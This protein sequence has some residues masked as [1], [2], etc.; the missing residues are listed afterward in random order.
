MCALCATLS[1]WGALRAQEAWR[2]PDR[3]ARPEA[4]TD[5]GGLWALMDRAEARLRRSPF[6]VRDGALRN[7]LHGIICRLTSRHCT[8]IRVY[9]VQNPLFNANMAPNGMTQVWTGLMLRMENEAQ[10]AAVLGHEIAHYLE[11]HTLERLRDQ[12]ATSA[13]GQFLGIFGAVGAIGQLALLAGLF[14]YS[15]EQERSADRIGLMLMH[16]AG[17]DPAE[18]ARVW[19]NLAAEAKARP[20]GEADLRIPLFATHPGVEERLETLSALAKEYA[21]GI[22]NA[23]TWQRQTLPFCGE[24]L[25]DEIQRGQ[26]EQSIV[27]LTR[28]MKAMPGRA[29]F[30]AARGEAYRLRGRQEDYVL[31]I[32][33]FKAAIAKHG[34]APIAHR[35]LGLVHYHRREREEA[36]ASFSRYLELAPRAPDA[37]MIKSYI[38]E[39]G[40]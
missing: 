25:T 17:Y 24:W 33:D 29:D 19:G 7:Y 16:R 11:R 32:A 18:A 26:Y 14:S 4:A 39:L 13:F 23:E 1:P 3:F 8:D 21:G 6:L 12:R 34:E 31:A 37:L 36:I 9:T 22:S 28:L 5:E 15:R 38:E 30:V 40:K 2:D 35:G 20:D 10:I 27:L